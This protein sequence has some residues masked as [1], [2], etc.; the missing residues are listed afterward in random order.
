[1][2]PAVRKAPASFAQQRLWFWEQLHPG[3]AAYQIPTATRLEGKLQIP[4]LERA[5]AVVVRRHDSLRMRFE[6][7]DGMPTVAV[8]D[9]GLIQIAQTD[10]SVVDPLIREREWERAWES[11]FETPMDLRSGPLWRVRLLRMA[12][13]DHRL[14]LSVHH[15]IYDM[16][17]H[18]IFLRELSEAYGAIAA[19]RKPALPDLPLNYCDFARQQIGA[20]DSAQVREDLEYWTARLRDF[21]RTLD[22]PAD[23][24]PGEAGFEGRMESRVFSPTLSRELTEA[25]RREGVTL[26]MFLLAGFAAFLHR[27]C[28]QE[29]I[30]I[31]V[32]VTTRNRV[33]FE[34]LIGLFLNTL[35][36]R[37]EIR[38]AAPVRDLLTQARNLVLEGI[39]HR[40]APFEKV[41]ERLNPERSLHSAP[42]FEVMFDYQATPAIS[43]T[44]GGVSFVPLETR[45]RTA[46]YMLTLLFKS[47]RDG[48]VGN[49]EYDS[50]LFQPESVRR[51]L[52]IMETLLEGM[53]RD[54]SKPISS[55][56]LLSPTEQQSYVVRWNETRTNYPAGTIAQAFERQVERT[57]GAIA[58]AWERLP[59]AALSESDNE[60]H[61]DTAVAGNMESLTYWQLN[62]RADS[63][64]RRLR[65]L[66]VGREVKVAICMDRSVEMIVGLLGILKAG[67][68]YVPLD[69]S[70][71]RD[72]IDTLLHD[73]Q[74]HLI[75]T[76]RRLAG[77]V[78]RSNDSLR[79][80]C[81]ESA[82]AD[83]VEESV[84]DSL[85]F[86]VSRPC[87]SI[88][89]GQEDDADMLAYVIYTSGSTGQ[90]KGVLVP[91]RGVVRLVKNTNYLRVRE[92]D[93]FLQFA[94]LSFDA[95]TFEIWAPLLN[96]GTLALMPPNPVSLE[97]LA[98]ALIQF[99]VTTLWL[100]SGLFHAMVDE[101]LE[102]LRTVRKLFTG[103]DVLSV[104]RVERFVREVPEVQLVNC[105]GP[106][107]NTTFTTW[108]EVPPSTPIV[109]SVP[110]G[111]PISNTQVYVLD[112]E[113]Q[114]VPVG[115]IGELCIGGGG[116]A[117]GYLN[118]PELT[119]EKFVQNP[120]NRISGGCL[121]RTGD[122][123]R[124]LADG[125][126]EFIG[127]R[128][129]Q[130]KVR[131]FRVQ[132]GEVETALRQ[133]PSVLDAVV[134]AT[135]D[136]SGEKRLVA[137]WVP[138]GKPAALSEELRE[139]LQQRLPEYMVP[140]HFCCLDALPLTRNGKIDRSAL[141][142]PEVIRSDRGARFDGPR[143]SI[144]EKLAAIWREVLALERVGINDSFFT[145]G[146]HSL[147]ATRA[148]SR[149][150]Q[151]FQIEV[152]LRCLFERRTIASLADWISQQ[153]QGAPSSFKAIPARTRGR[154]AGQNDVVSL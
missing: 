7:A 79:I 36:M 2:N 21:P 136:P 90:P 124:F 41:V 50:S 108:Y 58:L 118:A 93:V 25:S 131:G 101:R 144:E 123:V 52:R 63:L 75:L 92:G 98:R 84:P 68:A 114:P 6:A 61:A 57:P 69:A 91:N 31:G 141:P 64:A 47:T 5:L 95:S 119:A 71:P 134:A 121:Y 94:P 97:Q 139:F 11:E 70:Y 35:V 81:I 146:G 138:R 74:P 152:S 72:R 128:D 112:P 73:A 27:C 65:E 104:S 46:K 17:S 105:Y 154:Q 122:R 39:E 37:F 83:V 100:T 145:L 129:D 137:Y 113:L 62:A 102:A 24:S 99:R 116:L 130:V 140:S 38:H 120:F 148:V 82:L 12:E 77:L 45:T 53:A 109:R 80:I 153:Q 30:L 13:G 51:M 10:L 34:R 149:I 54:L 115:V 40:A 126:I 66:G 32:P 107:E 23:F 3:T 127:R 89:P 22:L 96:G 132:L 9:W 88:P 78:S 87:D 56:R 49:L 43:F 106:T 125:N 8:D 143:N 19:N 29:E 60:S 26:Y 44:S 15:I 135:L 33:E 133:N 28:G 42:L 16:W 14:L 18:D 151:C 85:D 111:R 1:M 59:G 103:G 48:L 110:I 4:A 55:L 142:L 117:R 150:S 147:L 67:G 76:E 20:V 86:S